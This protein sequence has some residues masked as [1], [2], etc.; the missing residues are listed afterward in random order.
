M[1]DSR[2]IDWRELHWNDETPELVKRAIES[3]LGNI[4]QILE[5]LRGLDVTQLAVGGGALLAG[6]PIFGPLIAGSAT[7]ILQ[8]CFSDNVDNALGIFDKEVARV[9]GYLKAVGNPWRLYRAADMWGKEIGEPV[10]EE[11]GWYDA[12]RM[13]V[14]YDWTGDAHDAYVDLL[15]SQKAAVE[16]VSKIAIDL[17]KPLTDCGINVVDFWCGVG[18]TVAMTLA[19]A[20]KAV[21]RLLTP[22]VLSV[23]GELVSAL[24][25]GVDSHLQNFLDAMKNFMASFTDLEDLLRDG[26]AFPGGH[27][28]TPSTIISDATR[29]NTEG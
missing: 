17:N 24:V 20:V 7:A 12:V 11:A 3:G 4:R 6:G 16:H 22:D 19:N 21:N 1:S 8:D 2:D 13:N 25:Q 27:W 29:W 10:S 23:P 28:P 15:P 18:A 9:L 14:T 26:A 5:S